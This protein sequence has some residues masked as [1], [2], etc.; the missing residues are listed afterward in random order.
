MRPVELRSQACARVR[1]LVEHPDQ[2]VLAC[3]GPRWRGRRRRAQRPPGASNKP[4]GAPK[5]P[6]KCSKA[7]A[8]KAQYA[9]RSPKTAHKLLQKCCQEAPERT[10]TSPLGVGAGPAPPG[11]QPRWRGGP[12]RAPECHK[13]SNFNPPPRFTLPRSDAARHTWHRAPIHQFLVPRTTPQDRS[14]PRQGFSC[15]RPGG[16]LPWGSADGALPAPPSGC[17]AGPPGGPPGG[18]SAAAW[19]AASPASSAAARPPGR[20]GAAPPR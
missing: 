4:Q 13:D 7:P 6:P 14:N 20:A 2:S 10:T 1:E 5:K 17:A 16:P 19:C 11:F 15:R 8:R 12:H 18:A 3:F 9:P